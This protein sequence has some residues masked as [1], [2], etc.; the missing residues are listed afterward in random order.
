MNTIFKRRLNRR[1][2]QQILFGAA[3]L[4]TLLLFLEAQPVSP[5]KHNALI[6]DLREMQK[7]DTELGEVV[8]QNHFRLHHNY[9]GMV[10][11][12]A[13]IQNLEAGLAQHQ[14]I[15]TL[16]STPEFAAELINLHGQ[17]EKKSEALEEFKSQNAVLKN[18]L[19]YLPFQINEVLANLPLP[20]HEPFELLVRD[21]LLISL[22]QGNQVDGSFR[23]HI[24][25]VDEY[26]PR[27]PERAKKPARLVSM[28]GMS[29]MESTEGISNV[30]NELSSQ[31]SDGL[32]SNLERLYVKYYRTQQYTVSIYRFLLLLSAMLM[33][34]YAI[35]LY[36]QRAEREEQLRIAA[37]AF[38]TQEGIMIT[39]A[40]NR[41][42]KVN[43][44]FQRITGYTAEDVMNKNPNILNSGRHGKEFYDAMWKSIHATGH[45]QGEIWDK[46]K[47][48]EIFPKWLTITAAKTTDGTVTH[49]V[50]THTD[51]SERKAAEAEIQKLAFYDHLTQLPNRRMLVHRL[52]EALAYSA[53]SHHLGA[54]L[55]IDL[56][57]FKTLNDT[58]GHDVGDLLLQEVAS[59]LTASLRKSDSISRAGEPDTVARLGGDEFVV[60]LEDLG[61]QTL[62]AATKVR[63]VGEKILGILNM[64]YRLAKQDYHCSASIG[65]TLFS[66]NQQTIDELMK[67]ADIAM[68]QAKKDG[69]ATVRFFDPQMQEKISTRARMEGD[70]RNALENHQFQL[71]YQIQVNEQG[72]ALGAESLIRWIHPD[73]GAISPAQFIPLA[74]ETGLILP[75]GLWVLETAC[76]QIKEWQTS[77]ATHDIGISVNVSAKQFRH[78]DFV[79]Q[80]DDAIRRYM[81]SPALL[82]LE[83]TETVMLEN[84]DDT[85]STM[86][87]LKDI[88]V[89]LSLDDFGTGYSSLQYL[90]KLPLDQ[91]KIDQSFVRDVA[92]DASDAAI[93]RTI[94]AMAQ[95]LGLDVIAEGVETHSQRQFLVDNG[96]RHFQGY[97]FGRPEPINQFNVSLNQH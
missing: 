71:H 3:A 43:Q 82:E 23:Q 96:C 17:I 78:V 85:I 14:R 52:G 67:Q 97:L 34:S 90:K 72:K 30:L 15:G 42:V 41:I 6:S 37:T 57:H 93:V 8:L 39:D 19:H 32:G 4:A 21:L 54:L 95:S 5:D 40:D 80:V 88:G 74:E 56:D 24:N 1:L 26:I 64:P 50:G 9:D 73:K 91:L 47:N 63:I 44:A 76:F 77:P 27:L 25:Q 49:Y 69:R 92:T 66:G 75:I 45:W 28:H 46:R 81:I 61:E 18:S 35:Y 62:Q 13:R 70:L 16:P 11:I 36:Y 51:I 83:L 79:K 89:R 86:R 55:F 59:R 20:Q 84:I 60:M 7:L 53:R 22:D 33:L 38:D 65:A 94:I 48:G 12:M 68:Y 58:L 87:R 31:Y 29:I 2:W 10:A